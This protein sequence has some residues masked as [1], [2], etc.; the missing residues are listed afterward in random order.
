MS[1]STTST[2]LE[3]CVLKSIAIYPSDEEQSIR[4]YIG[5][6]SEQDSERKYSVLCFFTEKNDT[7]HELKNEKF[8]L[9]KTFQVLNSGKSVVAELSKS[10]FSESLFEG[11]LVFSE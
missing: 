6:V 4:V 2:F 10:S 1:N 5:C 11:N 7:W 9:E 3:K 8:T